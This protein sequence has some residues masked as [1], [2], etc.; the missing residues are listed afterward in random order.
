M[1]TKNV[2]KRTGVIFILGPIWI[3]FMLL[4]MVIVVLTPA[5]GIFYYIFTGNDPIEEDILSLNLIRNVLDMLYIVQ[6][7]KLII[8]FLEVLS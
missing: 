6:K 3:T 7:T 8:S 1:N 5:W 4:Q 2:I